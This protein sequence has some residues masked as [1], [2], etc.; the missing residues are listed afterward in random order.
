MNFS[1]FVAGLA[2]FAVDEGFLTEVL[3]MAGLWIVFTVLVG[4]WYNVVLDG[5]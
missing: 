2:R 5:E 1:S 3:L 4:V